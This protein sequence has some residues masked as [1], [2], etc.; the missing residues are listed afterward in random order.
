MA[1]TAGACRRYRPAVETLIS[2][3]MELEDG[4]AAER[5]VDAVFGP[6][7]PSTG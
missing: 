1:R 6:L 4:H 5:V 3:Y 2:T 7:Q